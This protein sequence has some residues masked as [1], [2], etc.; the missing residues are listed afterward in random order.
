MASRDLHL[1]DE[2]KAPQDVGRRLA[3]MFSPRCVGGG[4]T[5]IRVCRGWDGPTGRFS[6]STGLE[7]QEPIVNKESSCVARRHSLHKSCSE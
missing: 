3:P 2:L 6:V 1:A 7:V 4:G 5:F